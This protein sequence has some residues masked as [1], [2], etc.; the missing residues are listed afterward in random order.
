MSLHRPI[1]DL[2]PNLGGPKRERPCETCRHFLNDYGRSLDGPHC[3]LLGMPCRTGRAASVLCGPDGLYHGPRS[4]LEFPW[5]VLPAVL[6]VVLVIVAIAESV[7]W[8]LTGNEP[9]IGGGG[10]AAFVVI[11]FVLSVIAV[12]LSIRGPRR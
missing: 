2:P 9:A 8:L 4:A 11:G 6:G 5:V 1:P 12:L 10:L 3:V 7:R